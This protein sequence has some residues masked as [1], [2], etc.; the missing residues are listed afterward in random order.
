MKIK[1]ETNISLRL[2]KLSFITLLILIPLSAGAQ[3]TCTKDKSFC[4]ETITNKDNN[5]DFVAKNRSDAEITS[6]LTMLKLVNMESSVKFPYTFSLEAKTNKKIFTLKQKNLLKSWNYNYNFNT[7]WG[8]FKAKHNDNYQYILPYNSGETYKVI[9]GY[10][11]TY[12]HK[13]EHAYS[14]DFDVPEGTDVLA[15]REGKVISVKN[16]SSI[17]GADKKYA[18]DANYVLIE[19]DDKTIGSYVHLL[20]GTVL[21]SIGQY[22]KSGQLIAKSGNTGW[23]SSPH[24][25]FWVYK[26]KDGYKVQSIPIKFKTSTNASEELKQGQ[27]Y[28]AF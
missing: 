8:N 11:G 22:V 17:G 19:H 18:N 3:E 25:H 21:V 16:D 15:S 23:S 6:T 4:I 14:I 26:A 7:I 12:S 20:K 13:G 10:N 27:S 2:R 9:Q 1:K 5:V 24:L 28:T